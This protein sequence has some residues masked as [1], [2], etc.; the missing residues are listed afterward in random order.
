MTDVQASIG[1]EQLKRIDHVLDEKVVLSRFYTK[2]FSK[3]KHV[4]PPYV[5]DYVDRPSWYMYAIVVSEKIRDAL[6]DYLNSVNIE[7]RL[8]FPPVHLQPY[9]SKELRCRPEDY[10]S[11]LRSFKTFLDIPIWAGMTRKNQA[12]VTKNINLFVTDGE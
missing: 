10:P 7:T 4:T 12:L 8:S 6:V 3:T 1:I 9:H 2:V 5:P 11:A